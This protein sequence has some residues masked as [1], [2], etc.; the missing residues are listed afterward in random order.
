[1]RRLPGEHLAP[2]CIM[3]RRQAGGGSV[4][5]W[6]MYDLEIKDSVVHVDVT[7]TTYL[8]IV[9]EH[10]HPFIETVF[11]DGCGLFQQDNV[12]CQRANT[13]QERFEVL[14]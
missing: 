1:M 11:T 3:G 13:V 9:A 4:M 10:V 12:P 7:N 5:L 2:R 14:T 8:T 6:A